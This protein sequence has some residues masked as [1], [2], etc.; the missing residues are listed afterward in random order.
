MC[1]F[2][3]GLFFSDMLFYLVLGFIRFWFGGLCCDGKLDFDVTGS[4]GEAA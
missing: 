2:S 3:T 4:S 1:N